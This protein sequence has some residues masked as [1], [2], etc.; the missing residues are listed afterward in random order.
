MIKKFKNLS[1]NRLKKYEKKK[2]NILQISYNCFIFGTFV[3]FFITLTI[4]LLIHI[5]RSIPKQF[6]LSDV[7]IVVIMNTLTFGILGREWK[8]YLLE[9]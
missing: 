9:L 4:A 5:D 8:R 3:G 7:F 2:N 6:E 1:E